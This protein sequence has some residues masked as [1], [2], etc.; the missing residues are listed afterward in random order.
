MESG[1]MK[2]WFKN[3]LGGIF[4]FLMLTVLCVGII[5]TA[6]NN[7][8]HHARPARPAATSDDDGSGLG[9]TPQ[10][11]IG[12]DAGGGFII[13]FDGSTPGPGFGFAP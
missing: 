13:P 5:W 6:A 10:G 4:I 9:I 1:I 7:T 12:I 11:K 8:G 3:N 2:R